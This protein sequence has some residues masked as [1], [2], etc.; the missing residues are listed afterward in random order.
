MAHQ[1]ATPPGARSQHH[2]TLRKF[3]AYQMRTFLDFTFLGLNIKR[4]SIPWRVRL[5]GGSVRKKL[6]YRKSIM[7]SIFQN[8]NIAWSNS[9]GWD[10]S[11]KRTNRG[12]TN[13]CNRGLPQCLDTLQYASV[14]LPRILILNE[15]VPKTTLAYWWGTFFR[16]VTLW[17]QLRT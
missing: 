8:W 17:L 16:K 9:R 11:S 4:L 7:A 1:S 15:R 6:N 13:T 10:K 2:Y 3:R 5:L 12:S 14:H